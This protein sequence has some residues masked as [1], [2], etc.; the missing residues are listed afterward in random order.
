MS[1]EHRG[2]RALEE[3]R[4]YAMGK[5]SAMGMTRATELSARAGYLVGRTTYM[6][7]D[8]S[9]FEVSYWHPKATLVDS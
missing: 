3:Q 6:L 8:H 4:D 7:A 9:W 5:P 2:K 1:A